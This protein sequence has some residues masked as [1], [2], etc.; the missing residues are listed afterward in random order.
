MNNLL[1]M[2]GHRLF[3]TKHIIIIVISI[4]LIVGLYFLSR[5]F[6]IKTL[7]KVLLGVGIVSEFTKIFSYIVMNENKVYTTFYKL[8][9]GENG[10]QV[11][12]AV[13]SYFAGVLPK[14]DLPFQLC[15]IQ[16]IFILIVNI[17][18]SEKLKRFILSFMMPSCLFGGL[19]AILI[20]T[21]SS[22]NVWVITFQY[23]LYHI[24][25]VVFALR[26]LTAKEMKWRVKDL[27]NAYIMIVGIMFFSIYINSI[28]F[29][30]ISNI[31]FMYVV[32]PPQSGLPYLNDKNG[33]LSY[34]IRYM[35]LVVV[36]I[37]IT[38]IG[39]IVGTIKDKAK[40]KK[41]AQE[42]QKELIEK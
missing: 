36:C 29:D 31:N 3:G 18:K 26:L 22:R 2:A 32:K 12:E 11:F 4:A 7:S 10:E 1:F 23:F 37:G 41:E 35:V 14:T 9:E 25:I 38:Y 17:S 39:A 30:G 6:S 5:K 33:W 40:A 16:I 34:I 15:S 13:E 8:A 21:E 20:A 28:L 42:P 27:L 24:A 19:A